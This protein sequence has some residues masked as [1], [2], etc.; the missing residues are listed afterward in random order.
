VGL[1]ERH[2]SAGAR[3]AD[4]LGHELPVFYGSDEPA[5]ASREYA[6]AR[7][8]AGLVDLSERGVLAVSGPTRQKFLQAILSNEV[9]SLAA[10]Q[11]RKAALLDVKGHVLALMRVLAAEDRVLLE[12]PG[13]QL[14]SVER[15]LVHYRVAAPVRFAQAPVTLVALIGPLA[16][17][18]LTR[19]GVEPPG[20]DAESHAARTLA[21]APLR[22]VRA[23]DLPGPAFVLH[24][25]PSSA[26]GA[27]EA[28]LAAG[29]APVGRVALDALRVEEGR[30]LYGVDVT[31]ENLLHET[32]LIHE[33]HAAK[34]CYVGQEVVARLEARGG[35]VSRALR[36]LRLE[37]PAAAGDDVLAG[38]KPVG[39]ITTAATSPRLGPIAMGYLHRSHFAPGTRVEVKGRAAEVA[40]LPFR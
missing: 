4:R 17:D 12:L 1:R 24:L 37:A 29:A 26:D 36:G 25:D 10:G 33:Y 19:A 31:D 7:E 5:A 39:R 15:A 2:A 18:V 13:R 16:S 22:A 30:P 27:W 32:G 14:E 3:F 21:G 28:L 9:A 40:S 35:N 11:G 20:P 34:G 6:V 38:G 23:G 8:A